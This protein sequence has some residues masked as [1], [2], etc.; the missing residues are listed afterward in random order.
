MHRHR[1]RHRHRHGHGHGHGHRHTRLCTPRTEPVSQGA[2]VIY[3]D[4]W[5]S[6]GQKAEAEARTKIF[7]PYQVGA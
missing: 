3:A 5:A 4:V 7:A 2:D 1:H 6:M